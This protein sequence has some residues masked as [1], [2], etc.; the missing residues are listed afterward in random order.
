M[1]GV[2]D[3]N[4]EFQKVVAIVGVT[5]MAIKFIAYW[6]TGSVSILTDAAESIVNVVAAFIGLYAL[7]LS[8]QPADRNHPF[9]HGKVEIISATIEGTLIIV[10]GLLIIM[11]S[12]QKLLHPGEL[13][14]LDLGLGLIAFTAIV[15]YAVGRSAI[16]KGRRNRSS[17]LEASGRHLCSDTLTS[18]GIVCGLAVVYAAQLRGYDA[19]W[20]DAS[21]AILFACVIIYTGLKVLRECVDDAMDK[22]DENLLEE[23]TECINERRHDHWVDVYGLRAVKYG[24]RIHVDVHVVMPREMRFQDVSVECREVD[25][26]IRS[27][28]GDSMELSITPVPCDGHNC[29][30]CRRRCSDR[31]GAFEDDVPWT[32]DNICGCVDAP[33]DESI[34]VSPTD[35]GS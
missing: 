29:P 8:A 17:A 14:A 7:Y 1:S 15:N 18:V 5:L 24:T 25:E 35:T 30:H 13:Q 31:D 27:R 21:I 4:Y 2:A 6:A 3:D 9:G 11:E 10:A 28:F 33:S 22:A 20:L 26:A 16:A 19:R 12:V 32:S 23:I 34:L